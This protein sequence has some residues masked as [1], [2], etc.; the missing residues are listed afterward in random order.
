MQPETYNRYS[1]WLH[2]TIAFLMLFMVFLGWRLGDHDS[3]R[4]SRINLHKSVGILVL[5]LSVVRIF[6]RLAYKAPPELP[7][8]RRWAKWQA[9]SARALHIGFYVAMMAMPLTGWAMVSTSIRPIPFFGLLTIPH[10]PLPHSVPL[11]DTFELSHELIARLLIFGMIPLHVA[12]ALK[13]H[14]LD[15]DRTIE[16]MVP[17]LKAERLANWRWIVP[18]GSVGLATILGFCL[19]RGTPESQNAAPPRLGSDAAIS[20][21]ANNPSVSADDG[22]SAPASST[23]SGKIPTWTIDNSR[24]KIAFETSFQGEAVSGEFRT[25]AATINFD[26]DQVDRSNIRV[27][28]DLSSVESSDADRDTTL[29]SPVFFDI[30]V[31]PRAVYSAEV[32]TRKDS[33]HF[34]AHGRLNMR[35]VDKPLDLPFTLVIKDKVATMTAQATIDRTVYGVGTGDYASTDVIPAKVKVDIKLAARRAG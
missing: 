34:V 26:P 1:R 4:L 19:L 3:L 2:W 30:A 10:L 21:I 7:P 17:G 29:K 32:F 5:A 25:Y 33:T 9:A 15:R 6:V 24:T 18:L 13:H 27:S 23:A 28:I 8:E 22:P 31:T 16:R 11:H 20:P 14:F 35:G 12:A